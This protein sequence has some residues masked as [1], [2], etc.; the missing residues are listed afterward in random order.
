MKVL[1]IGSNPSPKNTD[2]KVPFIGTRSWPRLVD[3]CEFLNINLIESTLINVS[4]TIGK[5]TKKDINYGRTTEYVRD[6]INDNVPIIVLGRVAEK[7]VKV[8]TSQYIYLPHPSGRNRTLNDPDAWNKHMCAVREQLTIAK[9]FQEELEQL[10][11]SK[12]GPL[13]SGAW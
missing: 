3:W 8:I 4:D 11:R 1:I 7:V 9:K 12:P 13:Q 5:L 6:A 2:P 10:R